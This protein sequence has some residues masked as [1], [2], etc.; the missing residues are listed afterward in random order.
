[1]ITI[2]VDAHS[3]FCQLAV[4]NKKDSLV[5][6][7][8]IET[9]Q[10][11]LI[12]F[13]TDIP[14][15]KTIV[16]EESSLSSWLKRSLSPYVNKVVVADPKENAWICKADVKN[17]ET[18]ANKLV[19]LYNADLIKEVYHTEDDDRI[20][21]KELV[22]H[23]HDITRQITRFKNKIKAEYR[24]KLIKCKGSSVY[25]PKKRNE[26][27]DKL[28]HPIAAFQVNNYCYILEKLEKTKAS[29]R[30]RLLKLNKKYPEIK[31]FQSIPGVGFITA[32]TVFAII[33][34]P[35]RF[36]KKSKL[37]TYAHLGKGE[38]RS[39]NTSRDK[40]AKNGN[41]LLKWVL[42]EAVG[43][44]LK[45]TND[46]S[47]KYHNLLARNVS[48]SMAKRIVARSILT[49]IWSMWKSGQSY[50]SKKTIICHMRSASGL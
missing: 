5:K 25:N 17:D 36:S 50:L 40:S 41:R 39:A 9:S 19:R 44:A 3:D 28:P 11:K 12:Q 35:H 46:F 33:D 24:Q 48:P 27:L 47:M 32:C 1:M 23:H 26:W 4:Y 7:V 8:Y 45:T 6:D 49:T 30:R 38:Y 31:N 43:G 29:I 34:T 42:M 20:F 2:G 10:E 14:K 13:L 18:D 16:F 21:F 15:P 37:W 22:L